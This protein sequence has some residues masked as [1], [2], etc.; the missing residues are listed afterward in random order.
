ML[1]VGYLKGNDEQHDA[2][3]HIQFELITQNGRAFYSTRHSNRDLLLL[4]NSC[5]LSAQI[6][7]LPQFVPHTHALGNGHYP[8]AIFFSEDTLRKRIIH[9]K[10]RP[11]LYIYVK[12]RLDH[13][14]K[15]L[16][17]STLYAHRSTLHHT[18]NWHQEEQNLHERGR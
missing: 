4:L 8:D 13:A 6:V 2:T 3:I 7:N 1:K 14:T 5:I 10:T 11:M 16:A 15:K 9:P 18:K 17:M 12:I